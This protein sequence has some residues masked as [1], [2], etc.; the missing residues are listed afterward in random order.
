MTFKERLAYITLGG[1]LVFMGQLLPNL[2][3]GH[4]AAQDG[5]ASAEFDE[6][7]CRRLK[8]IDDQGKTVALLEKE[9]SGGTYRVIQV[10]N[11]AQN[12][13]GEIGGNPNGGYIAVHSSS[14]RASASLEIGAGKKDGRV[15]VTNRDGSRRAQMMVDEYGGRVVLP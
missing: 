2:L 9:V 7:T 11:T 14:S 3:A 4:A 15:S 5:P 1:L 12:M 8:I 10:L 6:V 13:I